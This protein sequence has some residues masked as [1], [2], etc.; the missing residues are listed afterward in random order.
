LTRHR[1]L[2]NLGAGERLLFLLLF[3]LLVVD[4]VSV[5]LDSLAQLASM[6]VASL[7]T[8]QERQLETA[9]NRQDQK[10]SQQTSPRTCGYQ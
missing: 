9:G 10:A 2:A 3:P 4:A 1:C 8:R 6:P 7:A 5:I